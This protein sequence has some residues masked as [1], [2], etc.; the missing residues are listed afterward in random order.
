MKRLL[1]VSYWSHF[2]AFQRK[3]KP[4]LVGENQMSP[5]PLRELRNTAFF[6]PQ[7]Q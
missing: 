7:T 4:A 1:S 6:H 2:I 5:E 3:K